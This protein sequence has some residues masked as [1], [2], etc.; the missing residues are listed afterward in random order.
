M[1]HLTLLI[2]IGYSA[3]F[4]FLHRSEGLVHPRLQLLQVARV[5]MHPADVEPDAQIIVIPTEIA[6]PLPLNM[7]V[8]SVEIRKAH[9]GRTM[10]SCR[11]Y[12]ESDGMPTGKDTTA[13]FM[14]SS[15]DPIS[16]PYG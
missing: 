10:R 3:S 2:G 7:S 5:H 11:T 16:I 8:G 13:S 14:S 12:P 4:Q 9:A 6:E 15:A 1:T